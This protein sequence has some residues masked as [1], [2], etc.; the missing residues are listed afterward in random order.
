MAEYAVL[1]PIHGCLSGSV[2]SNATAMMKW[3]NPFE[4]LLDKYPKVRLSDCRAQCFSVWGTSVLLSVS[5]FPQGF[6][7]SAYSVICD[8]L[9]SFSSDSANYCEVI[10]PNFDLRCVALIISDVEQLWCMCWPF[11]CC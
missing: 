7:F 6:Q 11:V 4:V 2:L 3:R 10:A 9:S 5:P 8:T 1:L